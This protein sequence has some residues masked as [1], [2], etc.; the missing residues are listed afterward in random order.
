MRNLL[1][2]SILFVLKDICLHV[3]KEDHNA[4]LGDLFFWD[5]RTI[6][7]KSKKQAKKGLT[8]GW[9]YMQGNITLLRTLKGPP[10]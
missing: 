7:Q 3:N 2:K 8:K 6:S 1:I 5:W 9:N 4:S 10:T